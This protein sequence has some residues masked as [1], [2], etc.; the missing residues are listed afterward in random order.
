MCP[1]TD[2]TDQGTAWTDLDKTPIFQ[3]PDR[4]TCLL[5]GKAAGRYWVRLF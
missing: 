5:Y 3:L 4:V 1:E 2:A